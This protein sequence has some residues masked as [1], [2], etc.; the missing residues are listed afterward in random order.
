MTCF[1][2]TTEDTLYDVFNKYGSIT[3]LRL[4][5][6]HISGKSKGYAFVEY[7]RDCGFRTAFQ[8]AHKS[9]IDGR[10]ILV[11]YERERTMPG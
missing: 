5:C 9:L 7:E 1:I 6:D 3:S 10:Q 11:D 2:S 8:S 4:V